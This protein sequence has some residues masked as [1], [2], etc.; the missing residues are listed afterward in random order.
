M[1]LNMTRAALGALLVFTSVAGAQDPAR[2]RGGFG[3]RGEPGDS[4]RGGRGGM[5]EARQAIERLIR[6]QVKPTDAQMKQL[7]A[8]DQKYEPQRIQLNRDELQVRQ[9]LREAMLDSANVDESRI[10]QLL[11]RLVQFPGRRA[12]L[13][14][15]EQ[16]DLAG[17]LSPLQR[18]RYG[19]IQEQLRRRI[20]QGRGGR[21]PGP[22]PETVQ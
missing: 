1:N 12:A 18:A 15:S 4:M 13:M 7:Q 11:D 9:Q 14:E 5:K 21:P 16:K 22:P 10:G 8:V 2:G 20:E 3:R 19:A 6:T 17:F